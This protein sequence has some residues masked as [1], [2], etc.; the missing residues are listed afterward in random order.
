MKYRCLILD[1]DDT[2]VNSS[3]TIHHP[4]HL[5]SMRVLRP[6]HPPSTMEEWFLKNFDPGIMAYLRDEVGLNEEE[7]AAE[8]KVWRRFT[9]TITPEFYP[10]FVEA[11]HRYRAAGG[12]IAVVSHS[13]AD[14][15]YRHYADFRPDAV[16]GW[17]DDATKRKPS[18]WPI[19]QI[20]ERFQLPKEAALIV[21]DLKPGVLMAQNAGVSIAAAGW[22]HHIPEIE[23]YMREHTN[24]YLESVEQFATYIIQ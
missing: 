18:P 22:A 8:H 3:A 16:F 7:L 21:D 15:I 13:E 19:Q 4:A 10:G 17:V 5:E 24:A 11:L 9:T 23:R 12:I 6:D 2:A 14:I 1:H 20:L